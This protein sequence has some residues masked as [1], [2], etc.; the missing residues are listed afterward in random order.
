MGK[1][2]IKLALQ[3]LRSREVAQ[4]LNKSSKT[5]FRND[6]YK[7]KNLFHQWHHQNM[8]WGISNRIQIII[9][10]LHDIT[11]KMGM[12]RKIHTKLPG[13]LTPTFEC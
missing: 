6:L 12:Q 2:T 11:I 10:I 5:E 3:T 7:K 9:P 1:R 4:T 8:I 13:S